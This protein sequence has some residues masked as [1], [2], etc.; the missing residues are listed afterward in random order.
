MSLA[1][2]GFVE[3]LRKDPTSVKHIER[4]QVMP[5]R[6]GINGT[7]VWSVR[8]C[9]E[10]WGNSISMANFLF[11]SIGVLKQVELQPERTDA[12]TRGD[13]RMR[14]RKEPGLQ[15]S[16]RARLPCLTQPRDKK[17]KALRSAGIK[18]CPGCLSHRGLPQH[19]QMGF[20]ERSRSHKQTLEHGRKKRGDDEYLKICMLSTQNK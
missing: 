14:H 17:K 6:F 5:R 11:F 7:R 4:F 1:T 13:S 8:E 2:L 9:L 12:I 18:V 10:G 16:G 19:I 15:T 3:S 20:P